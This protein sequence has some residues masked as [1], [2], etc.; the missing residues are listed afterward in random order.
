M[1]SPGLRVGL[2]TLVGW[3]LDVAAP[4]WEG[5]ETF[6]FTIGSDYK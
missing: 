1:W 6:T 3:A 5:L 2:V 4:S